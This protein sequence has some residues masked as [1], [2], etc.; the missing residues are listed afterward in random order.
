MTPDCEDLLSETD[1]K[2]SKAED[3]K[4]EEEEEGGDEG[5]DGG[6]VSVD[7]PVDEDDKLSS[8]ERDELTQI[9]ITPSN[10]EDNEEKA[11]PSSPHPTSDTVEELAVARVSECHIV[12]AI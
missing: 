6:V 9:L 5:G 1:G 10:T 8:G 4:E 11:S 12:F 7:P 3:V 2:E